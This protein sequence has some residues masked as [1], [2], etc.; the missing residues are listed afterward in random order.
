M[1][2]MEYLPGKCLWI[3][4]GLS[5]QT[6]NYKVHGMCCAFYKNDRCSEKVWMADDV[7][8]PYVGDYLNDKAVSFKCHWHC[9]RIND[10]VWR[11]R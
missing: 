4:E 10:G 3:P 11:S 7:E 1:S 8:T 2:G 9:S 6:I 5:R